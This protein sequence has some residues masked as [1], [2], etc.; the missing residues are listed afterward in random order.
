MFN[1]QNMILGLLF[2]AVG[3]L[4]KISSKLNIIGNEM[5]VASYP[6]FVLIIDFILNFGVGTIF[7]IVGIYFFFKKSQE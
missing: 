2:I 4:F 6:Y 1:K 3:F 7:I 5:D